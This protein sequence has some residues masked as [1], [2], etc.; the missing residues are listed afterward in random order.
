M[1]GESADLET[2]VKS[3]VAG[4]LDVPVERVQNHASLI[5][6]LGAESIDFVDIVFRLESAFG[7]EIS[8]DDIWKGSIDPSSEATIAAGVERLRAT[9]PEFRWETVPGT[10]TRAELPA[11][12]TVRTITDY[13]R[14]RLESAAAS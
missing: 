8:E 4:A 11:L 13:M 3:I 14:K 6:D 2:R 12:I 9:M 5:N 10:I 1:S 7:I